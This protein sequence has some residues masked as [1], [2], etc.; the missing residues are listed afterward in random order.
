MRIILCTALLSVLA[1]AF[2]DTSSTQFV[3]QERIFLSGKVGYFHPFSTTLQETVSGGADYQ[4]SID[5][6]IWKFLCIFVSGDF[7]IKG[8]FST[9][10]HSS[11]TL[12]ILPITVGIKT[13]W[14]IWHSKTLAD[15]IVLY[16]ALG[17][18][19]Y[20]AN[21]RNKSPYVEPNDFASG[22]G[23]VGEAGM[24]YLHE[25][26]LLNIFLSASFGS[27]HS[28]SSMPNIATPPTQVGGLIAG[29]GIGYCF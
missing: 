29:G 19:Y 18:R 15:V 8:G 9:G 25:H 4:L 13:L 6:R 24:N 16:A 1:S 21:A 7:F 27:I 3:P 17:P 11:T 22:F 10:T 14:T 2:S 12:W 5:Y 23:G 20:F 26:F 28:Q